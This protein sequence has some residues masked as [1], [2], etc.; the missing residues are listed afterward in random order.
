MKANINLF[1]ANSLWNIY[2]FTIYIFWAISQ[3]KNQ[4]DVVKSDQTCPLGG[5]NCCRTK[6]YQFSWGGLASL[7]LTHTNITKMPYGKVSTPLLWALSVTQHGKTDFSAKFSAN[8]IYRI[9]W[10]AN[11]VSWVTEL[12]WK[13]KECRKLQHFQDSKCTQSG[14]LLKNTWQNYPTLSVTSVT[15]KEKQ[16]FCD[17]KNGNLPYANGD[18][19]KCNL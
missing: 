2:N 17:Y 14:T 9:M 3:N 12:V 11:N 13:L 15:G 18:P 16:R 19:C 7:S 6:S 4:Y 5:Q 1:F 8:D 10:L